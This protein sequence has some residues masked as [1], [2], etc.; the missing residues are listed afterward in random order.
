MSATVV[1]ATSLDRV[2]PAREY[3]R[4]VPQRVGIPVDWRVR[5]GTVT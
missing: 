1:T 5:T 2:G 3:S 4:E